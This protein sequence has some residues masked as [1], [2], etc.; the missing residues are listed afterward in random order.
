MLLQPQYKVASSFPFALIGSLVRSQIRKFFQMTYPRVI[1]S[2]LNTKALRK[3][4][5]IMLIIIYP[6]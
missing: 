2:Q 5:I 6:L 1:G 4:P 3:A